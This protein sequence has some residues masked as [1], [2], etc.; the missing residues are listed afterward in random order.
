MDPIRPIDPREREFDRVYRVEPLRDER[1]ERE[2]QERRQRREPPE[3]H[4]D[5]EPPDEEGHVIDV[6]V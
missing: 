1:R 4:D 3:R 5:D 6:R 2:Q